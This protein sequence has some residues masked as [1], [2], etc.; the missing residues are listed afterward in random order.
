MICRQLAAQSRLT[1]IVVTRLDIA[2]IGLLYIIVVEIV[3]SWIIIGIGL[4]F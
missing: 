2:G 1:S 4:Q 3:G